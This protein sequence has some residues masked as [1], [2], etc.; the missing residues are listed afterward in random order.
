MCCDVHQRPV[1]RSAQTVQG[2]RGQS[3]W[4]PTGKAGLLHIR[5]TYITCVTLCMMCS[6]ADTCT[7]VVLI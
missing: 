7:Y 2:L 4:I 6:W 3:L 1:G 5:F